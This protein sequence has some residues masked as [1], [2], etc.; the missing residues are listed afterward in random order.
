MVSSICE[1]IRS[2]EADPKEYTA[3]NKRLL[4]KWDE[5]YSFEDYVDKI[6]KLINREFTIYPGVQGVD[7]LSSSYRLGKASLVK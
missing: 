4:V 2:L 7:V 6:K 3:L 5:L 1:T